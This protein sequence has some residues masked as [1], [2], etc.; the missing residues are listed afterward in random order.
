[1][2]LEKTE[3]KGALNKKLVAHF[4]LSTITGMR[5][6]EIRRLHDHPEWYSDSR[7]Q[8]RLNEEAQKK[9]KGKA[10]ERTVDLMPS[11]LFRSVTSF[12]TSLLLP[13]LTLGTRT[14]KDGQLKLILTF[15]D[16][17]KNY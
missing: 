2:Y 9:V 10:K 3:L 14:L 7:N 1:M 8:I 15:W 13:M 6:A 5:Y 12:S 17:S 11:T 4:E 16:L